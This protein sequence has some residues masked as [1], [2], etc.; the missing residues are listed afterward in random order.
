MLGIAREHKRALLVAHLVA[1]FAAAASVPIPLLLPLLVD[2]VLLHKPGALT[3]FIDQRFPAAWHGPLLY[4]G[5][6]LVATL[7][8]RLSAMLAGVWQSRE[9]T[10]IAKDVAYR[11]RR[12]MLARLSR[13]ALSEYETLGSGTVASHFVT[14]LNAVDD[15]IGATV[16][17]F[18]V[19]ALSLLGMTAVLLWM[20]WQL[21]LFILLLNPL[22]IYFTMVLG[23]KVKDLKRREN[24]A[25]ELF[26]QSLTETLDAIQQIRALNRERHYI[27]RVA[28]RARDIRTHAAAF[29]WKSDAA[30]RASFLVFLFGFDIF[31]GVSMLMVVYSNLSIGEM[32]AVFGYLWFMMGPVQDILGI[33]Y[34]WFGARAALTRINHLLALKDEP[35]YPHLANPF[36][37]RHTV[38]VEV[39]DVRF[40]YAENPVLNGVSLTIQAGEKVALVGASGGGK[41]TLVQIIL[42]LYQPQSGSVLFDG[43]PTTEIGLDVVRENVASVLQHPALFNDSVRMN[44]TLGR[45]MDETALWRALAVA[46]LADTVQAMP[47]GLDTLVGRQGVRL[48]G[49]QRQRLA[50]ARMIL[51]DPRV[52]ILDEA[53]SALDAATE[54]RLHAALHDFLK[55]R[56]TL[57]IA[58]RLSAVKQA[59]RVYVFDGGQI[60]EEG[61]HAEL[62]RGG[63]LY[64]K[65]YGTLQ[66]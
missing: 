35:Q 6:V 58:H 13:I 29:S 19:A 20:H 66:H 33:Q 28:E 50:I 30:S 40:R 14:D 24:S 17:K 9:F 22:V 59:D 1:L 63:G 39:R 41:S 11:L 31:R 23:K 49:G 12:Q 42:G 64:A 46:Q 32:M 43:V 2:Q 21:A 34:A 8:L 10:L 38:G 54:A 26:Q 51:A 44:L 3:H 62:I 57:I 27:A 55:D 53:T 45:D 52:V 16:A 15:F 61:A 37:G 5:A 56:T 48:S 47:G 36:A 25:F 18:V 65:L 60:I 7:V 4:I